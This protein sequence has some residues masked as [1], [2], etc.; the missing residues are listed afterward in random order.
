MHISTLNR[1]VDIAKAMCPDNIENRCSHIAFLIKKNKIMHIGWNK[2]KTVPIT[3]YHPYHS[4]LVERH[5]EVDVIFKSQRDDLWD[6]SLIVLRVSKDTGKLMMS[7]PC[8]GCSSVIR[9][10]GIKQTYYSNEHGLIITD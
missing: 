6:Y 3:R 4:G 5:A 10:F 7:R 1:A 8:K 2:M 9:Q